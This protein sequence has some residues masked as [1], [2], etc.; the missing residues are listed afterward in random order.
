MKFKAFISNVQKETEILLT[1]L[2]TKVE[3]KA[4][5]NIAI[6]V[7]RSLL[8][9]PVSGELLPI[10]LS[11]PPP[12]PPNTTPNP[13]HSQLYILW[14]QFAINAFVENTHAMC[15]N[16]PGAWGWGWIGC[17]CLWEWDGAKREKGRG[18]RERERD[19]EANC[20]NLS[21]LSSCSQRYKTTETQH[22]PYMHG[23]WR[24]ISN[25]DTS[26]N[27]HNNRKRSFPVRAS[28]GLLYLYEAWHFGCR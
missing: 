28:Y 2:Y 21:K 13:N 23:A 24:T 10:N 7:K 27:E 14:T 18:E 16:Q 8:F 1:K 19:R 26:T 17:V 9:A 3:E 25:S 22:R 11:P 20:T 15:C 5:C 4:C 12:L 6:F